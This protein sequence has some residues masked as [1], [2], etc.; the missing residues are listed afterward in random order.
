M[1][2]C[3]KCLTKTLSG[4]VRHKPTGEQP[5]ELDENDCVHSYRG[6]DHEAGVDMRL[7]YLT[8]SDYLA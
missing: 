1:D 4:V 7:H 2:S 6:K 3:A 8:S 5:D